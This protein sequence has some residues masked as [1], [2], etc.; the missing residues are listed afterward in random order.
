MNANSG[1]LRRYTLIFL[2]MGLLPLL[3]T[4][5][6]PSAEEIVKNCYYKYAGDDQRSG[7]IAIVRDAKGNEKN[8]DFIRLW[9]DYG[10]KD[11]LIDKV[12][13]Y[14]LTP[15]VNKDIAFMRWGYTPQSGKEADQWVYLPETRMIRRI[16]RRDPENGDWGLNDDELRI[17][18]LDEDNHSY[19]GVQ[20]FEGKQFYVV[21]SRPK[22]DRVYS[23]RIA[24]YSKTGNWDTCAE[25]RLDFFD[26]KDE[27]VKTQYTTWDQVNGAWIWRTV[28]V[29]N[30][31][32]NTTVIYKMKD[33][34]VNVGLEDSDFTQRALK[35]GY[36]P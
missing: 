36:R 5:Q 22:S 26:K 28:V 15:I 31:Q 6:E 32:T 16:A 19:L 33:V 11:G 12:I 10:G 20:V 4:A 29:K 17:R 9:K 8:Y 25:G 3:A 13:I 30:V 27:L 2:V 21:E 24:W 18:K 7:L 34:E 1:F 23:K 14:T 35:R